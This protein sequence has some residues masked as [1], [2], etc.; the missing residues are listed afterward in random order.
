MDRR[1]R[2]D[3]LIL[4]LAVLIQLSGLAYVNLYGKPSI[5]DKPLPQMQYDNASIVLFLPFL[6]AFAVFGLLS[7]ET[8]S[9][10]A[11]E[12][13]KDEKHPAGRA[14]WSSHRLGR[15]VA[16]IVVCCLSGRVALGEPSEFL[17][18]AGLRQVAD[19]LVCK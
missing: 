14:P 15:D 4:W 5:G 9:R 18:P 6:T 3:K 12:D 13:G 8:L 11:R 1:L 2:Q 10:W 16:D 7:L 17:K 19:N